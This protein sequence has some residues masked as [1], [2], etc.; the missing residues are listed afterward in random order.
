VLQVLIDSQLIQLGGMLTSENEIRQQWDCPNAWP[1]LQHMIMEAI[2]FTRFDASDKHVRQSLTDI[3][4]TYHL[5]TI[6]SAYS[7]VGQHV[8]TDQARA[9]SFYLSSQWCLS[10]MQTYMHQGYMFEKYNAF[11]RDAGHGGEYTV[12]A[13]FGWSNG[14]N[15]IFLDH[16]ASVLNLTQI[17]NQTWPLPPTKDPQQVCTTEPKA[18]SFIAMSVRQQAEQI[19]QQRRWSIK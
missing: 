16:Y 19:Q 15:L 10:N 4:E 13:G 2:G 12:Q 1:P 11:T 14:V 5:D 3:Y 6:P 9:L 7:A 18:P 17:V 8:G